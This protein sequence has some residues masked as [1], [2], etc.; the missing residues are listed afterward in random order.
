V[1]YPGSELEQLTTGVGV[2][3]Y[4][5][6]SSCAH[7]DSPSDATLN[8]VL[9]GRAAWWMFAEL[10]GWQGGFIFSDGFEAGDSRLWSSSS[11]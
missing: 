4:S 11:M 3:G 5:G 9:K 1:D 8:C 10:A 6:L 2:S 7:S